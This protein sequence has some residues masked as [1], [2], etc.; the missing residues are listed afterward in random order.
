V[1]TLLLTGTF[2]TDGCIGQFLNDFKERGETIFHAI[3]QYLQKTNLRLVFVE[4]SYSVFTLEGFEDRFEF[5]TFD[6]NRG[7]K[8][9]GK[10]HAE[11]KAILYALENSKFLKEDTTFFK[12]SGR[13]VSMGIE[14]VIHDFDDTKYSAVF[15]GRNGGNFYT[16][17]FGMNR[18]FYLSQFDKAEINDANGR[19]YEAVM[20]EAVKN[21]PEDRVLWI[22]PLVYHET[23]IGGSMGT[24]KGF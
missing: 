17:F 13:Y 4:N 5:L 8:H 20:G 10:G 15:E 18:D 24:F 21:I 7:A 16:V 2:N 12:V 11:N 19:I 14:K 1:N 9:Y 3:S 22:K 23:Q 6:G